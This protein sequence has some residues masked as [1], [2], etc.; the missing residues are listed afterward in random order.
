[1]HPLPQHE[2]LGLRC[3]LSS[4]ALTQEE[5]LQQVMTSCSEGNRSLDIYS[6]IPRWRGR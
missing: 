6:L 3:L 5:Q 4:M 2:R 1:M